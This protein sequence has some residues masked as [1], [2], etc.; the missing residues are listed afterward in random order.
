MQE[1]EAEKV[2]IGV[3]TGRLRVLRLAKEAAI[4]VHTKRKNPRT[5]TALRGSDG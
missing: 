5:R 4:E 3:K 1:Y 2:A